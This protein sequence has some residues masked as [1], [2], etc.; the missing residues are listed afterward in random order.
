MT[1]I[2]LQT[3]DMQGIIVSGY[4]HLYFSCYL[5]LETNDPEKARQWLAILAETTTTANWSGDSDGVTDKPECAL[6]IAFTALGLSAIGLRDE[7]LN[8]FPQ[9][10]R[11]GMTEESRSRRLGDNGSSAP[12][13][14]DIGGVALNGV[15]R[16]RVHVLLILQAPSKEVLSLQRLEQEERMRLYGIAVIRAEE[17]RRLPDQTE[18]FGFQDSISQP[19]IEGG[20]K[21]LSDGQATTFRESSFS[22]IRTPTATYHLHLP[23]LDS[24]TSRDIFPPIG[25]IAGMA[26]AQISATSV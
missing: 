23:S 9:E 6:N 3:S 7:S 12:T 13:N 1:S 26:V 11:E 10:F 22:A 2:S 21:K 5:F 16:D 17:G 18:H 14:W 15:P 20:P 8:T 24:V 19:E 4:G 25:M